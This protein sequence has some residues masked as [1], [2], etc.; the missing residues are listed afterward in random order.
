MH[1][2]LELFAF[3]AFELRDGLE[4]DSDLTAQNRQTV[5]EKLCVDLV[6]LVFHHI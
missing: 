4:L 5:L 6:E 2:V 1:H 3:V